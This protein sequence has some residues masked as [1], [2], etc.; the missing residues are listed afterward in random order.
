[1][2]QTLLAVDLF[3]FA[4]VPNW[5]GKLDDLAVLALEEPWRFTNPVYLTKNQWTPILER[6]IHMVFRKQAIDY[7]NEKD[8]E[9]AKHYFYICNEAACFHTGLY[10]DRYKPIYACFDRNKRM[11]SMLTW[12]F[13]GF[14]DEVNTWMK[15]IEP[16]PGKPCHF[17]GK[18]QT[19]K[20]RHVVGKVSLIHSVDSLRLLSS[21]QSEASR[22]TVIQDILF[23]INLGDEVSK[24][25]AKAN[26]LRILMDTAAAC[27]NLKVRG[28]MAIPPVTDTEGKA[29]RYFSK[30]RELLEV[31]G[32][33]RY[34]NAQPDILSMGMSG[35]YEAA[36]REGATIV[37]IGRGIYGE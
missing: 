5:Y 15:Y 24:A 18:L 23:E 20:V 14:A 9:K 8:P 11:D 28:L 12:Y 16:L 1:M 27:P 2:T 26:S 13:R 30:L 22:Q 37:R 17:I 19:N 34:A 35:S 33:W 25:G 6:Y 4:Y 31:M 7:N 32:T 3:E 36:I 21:L 29:R 10:T